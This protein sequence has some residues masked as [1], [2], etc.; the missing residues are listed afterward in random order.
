MRPHYAGII[1][2]LKSQGEVSLSDLAKTLKMSYTGLQPHCERLQKLGFLERRRSIPTGSG[3]PILVYK[4]AKKAQVFFPGED[5]ETLIKILHSAA[6]LF[7]QSAP[8]RLLMQCFQER[9]EGMATAVGRGKSIAEKTTRLVDERQKSGH[10]AVCNYEAGSGFTIHEYH[11]PL[12][13]ILQEFPSAIRMEQQ[14][15]ET[16]LGSRIQRSEERGVIF[17][18]IN[19]L[20]RD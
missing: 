18:R 9:R 4:L 19:T 15:M 8:E 7:G 11:H 14:G 1:G 13:R 10:V 12:R 5:S 3:R 16:L 20:G 6:K 17:Y 2:V